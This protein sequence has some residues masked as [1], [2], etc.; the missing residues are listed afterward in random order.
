M[1]QISIRYD[2]DLGTTA[3][4]GPSGAVLRTDAPVDNMGRGESFSPTD[5]LATA[6]GTCVLTTMAIVAGCEAIPFD[7]AACEVI[8]EMTAT[9]PRRI[10]TLTLRIHMPAGLTEPQ[11][12]RLERVAHTC[13]VTRSL[14]P[15]VKL[16]VSF[17]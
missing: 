6:L 10:A 2:G 14:H 11:R 9:A 13:P 12:Q 3:T 15:D 17:H 4:H 7:A 8:K 1:V 16:D 5:L